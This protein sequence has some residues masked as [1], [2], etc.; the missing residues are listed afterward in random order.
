[1]S[2]AHANKIAQLQIEVARLREQYSRI[3]TSL[4]DLHGK[5]GSIGEEVRQLDETKQNRRG[6]KPN[7]GQQHPA[8]DL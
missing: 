6:P 2:Q 8:S 5:I 1:M 7:G 3:L 4:D